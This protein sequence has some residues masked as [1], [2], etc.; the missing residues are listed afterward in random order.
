MHIVLRKWKSL[1]EDTKETESSDGR[2]VVARICYARK[3]MNTFLSVWRDY[4][5]RRRMNIGGQRFTV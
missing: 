2:T 4:V 1:V 3:T 5:Q